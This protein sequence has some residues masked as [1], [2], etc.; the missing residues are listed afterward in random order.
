MDN[1]IHPFPCPIY[2]NIIDEKSFFQ[3]QQDTD[4]FI[5]NNINL[6]QQ[7]WQ[8]PTLTTIKTPKSQN[9]NSTT[10][11]KEIKFFVEEYAK[12]WDWV[13]SPIVEIGDCWVNIAPKGAYQ[14]S[15]IHGDCLFSGVVYLNVD[16]KSGSFQFINPLTP[17]SIL[18]GNP[19]NFGYFYN[20]IP[21]PGMIVL[22]PGWMAHRALYNDSNIDRISIS[23]N[24]TS[25]F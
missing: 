1:L 18:L 13:T 20:I 19:D 9:I 17:E 24:I 10:L 7:V 14:E 6:F 12:F 5:K 3:I 15:H 23:F 25:K 2:Q 4:D 21:Q 8:C 22:F 11:T 16:E